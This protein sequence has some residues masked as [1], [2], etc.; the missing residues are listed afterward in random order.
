MLV[1]ETVSP[2]KASVAIAQHL[3]VRNLIG[4]LGPLGVASLAEPYGL[5]KGML[6]IPA[7]YMCS[8]AAFFIFSATSGDEGPGDLD[9]AR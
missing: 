7:F 9:V 2:S 3:C 8:T 4:G 5:Q 1:R 6:L